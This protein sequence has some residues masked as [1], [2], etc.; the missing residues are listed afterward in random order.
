MVSIITYRDERKLFAVVGAVIIAASIAL[1]QLQAA[2]NGRPSVFTVAVQSVAVWLESSVAS[3]ESGARSTAAGIVSL[4]RLARENADLRAQ[5]HALKRENRHLSET[6]AEDPDAGALLRGQFA[7][8]TGVAARV[9]GYDPEKVS[10]TVTIDRGSRAGVRREA[11][12]LTDDGAVGRVLAVTP[13]AATVLLITDATSKIPAVV[14]RGR[15]WGIATGSPQT[16]GVVLEYVS[17]DAKMRAGDLVVTGEGRSFHAGI[18]IGTIASVSASHGAL[19]QTASLTPTA[20]LGA[21][22]RVLVVSRTDAF[23]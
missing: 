20:R 17:Q 3:V 10:H 19:Y 8:P 12:V 7:Y 1:V 9:V 14:Q 21:L 2:R 13:F 18:P 16:G 22:D 11:G 5:V 23:Q 4:P 6:L 15:W